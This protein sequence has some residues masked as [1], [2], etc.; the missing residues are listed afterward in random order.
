VLLD[1]GVPE[2]VLVDAL[3]EALALIRFV[4]DGRGGGRSRQSVE[5]DL[6]V[7]R[8]LELFLL[9]VRD[10]LVGHVGGVVGGHEA[11]EFREVGRHTCSL[12]K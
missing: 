7:L 6:L 5:G 4:I 1:V 2:V 8:V 11:R 12:F 9:D 3:A 10:A